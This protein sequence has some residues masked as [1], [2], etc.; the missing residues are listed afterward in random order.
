MT[1]GSDMQSVSTDQPDLSLLESSIVSLGD[2]IDVLSFVPVA[3]DVTVR[4]IDPGD[5]PD[6]IDELEELRS[7]TY[8][9]S[10]TRAGE[11][12]I[13][14]AGSVS[15]GSSRRVVV[16]E[17]TRFKPLVD[18][19]GVT[20]RYGYVIRFCLTVNKWNA[21]SQLSLPFLSAQA[22]LG[23]IQ[24]SWMMQIRGLVGPKIDEVVLPPQELKVETFV[25]AKQSIEKVIRAVND[26]STSFRSGVLL[27]T[28]DPN[29]NEEKFWASVVTSYA[30]YSLRK[31]RSAVEAIDRLGLNDPQAE[32]FI[33]DT[34]ANLGVDNP[35]ADPPRQARSTAQRIMQGIR[36][37]V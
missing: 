6:T 23:N 3:T 2:A 22:Q 19:T 31:G 13:P 1:N 32:D 7:Y 25:I 5:I 10:V 12:N 34:Y 35:T 8:D 21:K 27:A 15:G 11:L 14:V 28:I 33:R 36:V 20:Y 24:A 16:Y 26:P 30:I 4:G 17:W 9:L 37:D 18:G 29:S